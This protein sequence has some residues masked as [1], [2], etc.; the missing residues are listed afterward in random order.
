MIEDWQR[1]PSALCRLCT[2]MSAPTGA[3]AVGSSGWNGKWAPHEPVGVGRDAQ[4]SVAAPAAAWY[5]AATACCAGVRR[6]GQGD[7]E[8]GRGLPQRLIEPGVVGDEPGAEVLDLLT[9]ALLLSQRAAAISARFDWCAAGRNA[10]FCA[11]PT[12]SG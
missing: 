4:P 8:R 12:P 10:V 1:A 9:L 6:V 2:T 11:A 5:R 7:A 3:A